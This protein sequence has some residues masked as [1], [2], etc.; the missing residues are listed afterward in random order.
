MDD[1]H[2]G[3]LTRLSAACPPLV[4]MKGKWW[5]V[6][7]C[8]KWECLYLCDQEEGKG[9]NEA[10]GD[11]ACEDGSKN[12]AQFFCAVVGNR[13]L[14]CLFASTNFWTV[15][16]KKKCY[17]LFWFVCLVV[18]KTLDQPCTRLVT[19]SLSTTKCG[20]SHK[21]S[22]WGTINWAF[23]SQMKVKKVYFWAPKIPFNKLYNKVVYLNPTLFFPFTS[24]CVVDT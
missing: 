21:V 2:R 7:V 13:K 4:T 23:C 15:C 24:F 11:A 12:W 20:M 22:S 8:W 18:D 17:K 10:G 19:L 3:L 5:T 14:S 16:R 1:G 9:H 6:V